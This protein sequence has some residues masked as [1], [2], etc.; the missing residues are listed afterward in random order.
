MNKL[1]AYEDYKFNWVIERFN[2]GEILKWTQEYHD[3]VA[4]IA[5]EE[6]WAEDLPNWELEY[7]VDDFIHDYG[8]FGSCYA[9]FDEFCE[10]DYEDYY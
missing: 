1:S 2:V 4:E 7:T 10:V 5:G 8:F 9:C 6:V 3:T